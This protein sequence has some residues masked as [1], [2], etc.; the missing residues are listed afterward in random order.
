MTDQLKQIKQDIPITLMAKRLGHAIT[1]RGTRQNIN[2]P[3]C[4]DQKQ[5]LQLYPGS[6]RYFCHKCRAAGDSIDLAIKGHNCSIQ[7]V[8]NMFGY[9]DSHHEKEPQKSLD[10][11]IKNSRIDPQRRRKNKDLYLEIS[12]IWN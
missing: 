2:C 5:H 10:L 9:F 11:S 8:K 3:F 1:E 4:E 7:D 6:N 12:A